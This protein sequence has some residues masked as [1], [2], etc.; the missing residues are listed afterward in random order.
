MNRNPDSVYIFSGGDAIYFAK[1]M[2]RSIF[3]VYNLVI[4]GLARIADYHAE[5]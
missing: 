3:V 2:K 4:M 5:F 1:R